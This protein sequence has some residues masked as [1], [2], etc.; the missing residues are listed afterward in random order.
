MNHSLDRIGLL[1]QESGKMPKLFLLVGPPGSGKSTFAK[2]RIYNDGDHGAATAYVN[3]DSQGKAG[4]LQAFGAALSG[5]RDVIVDRMNFNKPQRLGYIEQAK[6][7]GYEIEIH[8]F[9]EPY[10]VCLD[11]ALARKGHETI[12]EPKDAYQAIGFFFRKYERVDDNEADK[13]VRHYPIGNKPSAII[14]DLDGTLADCAHRRHFVRVP[15]GQKKNWPAFFAGIK[16]D[17]PNGFCVDILK[18]FYPDHRIVFCSGRGEEQREST[19]TWLKQYLP[20]PVYV[21]APLYM[22]MNGDSR[23]D[24]IV[25]EIILDFEILTRFTP[26]FML[27]DRDQVVEMWRKRGFVCLQVAEGD[28]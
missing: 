26:Y 27:D 9:H 28:F 20:Y 1:K 8:V 15:E 14:C 5:Y 24:A 25:K 19:D 22:R 4:H 2:E 10:Q 21:K 13:V 17:T 6:R 23:Q 7:R 11:R 16:D 18:R 3:Q 12:V